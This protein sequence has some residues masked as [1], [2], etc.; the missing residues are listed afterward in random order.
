M[1]CVTLKEA[2]FPF[3]YLSTMH[4]QPM[5]SYVTFQHSLYWNS[6]VDDGCPALI[7]KTCTV[8]RFSCSLHLPSQ[9][10]IF[11]LFNNFFF[12]LFNIFLWKSQISKCNFTQFDRE[13]SLE[14]T[15][16]YGIEGIKLK[17]TD[18]ATLFLRSRWI[19]YKNPYIVN[20][21]ETFDTSTNQNVFKKLN[22]V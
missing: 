19:P 17:A 2:R 7:K 15:G 21:S 12:C 3:I 5:A 16:H 11:F 4:W 9:L 6:T 8:M 18:N 22:H 13:Q 1:S 14:I 20:I 10:W